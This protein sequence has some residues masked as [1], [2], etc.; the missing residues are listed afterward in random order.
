MKHRIL[1]I[2]LFFLPV[3]LL[4][5]IVV[6]ESPE[7]PVGETTYQWLWVSRLS[8]LFFACT[9]AGAICIGRKGNC[10]PAFYWS[11]VWSLIFWG[12]IE[13]I[14]GLRQIYGFTSSNHSLYKLTGSFFNPGPYS[15]YLAMV[16]PV[17]LNEWFR[18][19][20]QTG[21]N[22]VEQIGYYLAGGVALLI[23]CVLPAG[24]SRSAWMATIVSGLWVCG[25]HYSWGKKW[26][27]VWQEYRKRATIVIVM[28]LIGWVIG[29]IAL[30]GLKKDSANGRLFMWKICCRAIA[31]RPLTG[32]GIQ[33]FAYAYGEEQEKYF[34]KGEYTAQEEKV[35]GSPEYAFNEYLQTMM[36]WGI[37]VFL[38]ILSFIAFS[39][40]EGIRKE[41]LSACGGIISLLVFAFSSYPM[42]LPVFVVS[43]F[44][45]I[46]AC[47]AGRSYVGWVVFSFCVGI[48]GVAL[49]KQNVYKECKEWTSAKILYSAG[50]YDSAKKDYQKLCPALKNKGAFLFEYGHC[51]HKL[52]EY[53]ASNEVLK[54]A[55]YRN[56]DPMILNIIA[57]NYQ[58][59]KQYQLA[60]EYFFRSIHRLPGRIYPY[61]LL[62]KLYAECN[63]PCEMKEVAEIVLTKDPKV[64]ST[65]VKEMKA[66]IKKLL[67]KR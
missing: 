49:W 22:S 24:M 15:G 5:G 21:R 9:V 64:Q 61:Y 25:M 10:F 46:A 53:E 39:L 16:F 37:T 41:R 43:F 52:G 31:E 67:L 60:E 57:K 33:G 4:L 3:F 14:W 62:A 42:Q 7:L 26:K 13:A 54:Q 30:F 20:K 1:A 34:A 59:M 47:V 51:L 48:M 2:L 17:S 58:Q 6:V 27:R 40:F 8:I 11:V 38:L 12:G 36:E 55:M 50:A 35:A 32:Y 45:L 19:K 56:N 28:V 66:E 23:V 29:G 44:F 65:A 18:L 63:M